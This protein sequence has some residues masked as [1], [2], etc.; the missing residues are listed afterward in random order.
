MDI[1]GDIRVG[2]LTESLLRD[3]LIEIAV[4]HPRTADLT[5]GTIRHAWKVAQGRD[6]RQP[7]RIARR[8]GFF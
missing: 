5:R 8:A 4:E 6:R 3:A 7:P 1:V 2:Q